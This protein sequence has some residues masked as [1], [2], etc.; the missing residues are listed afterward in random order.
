MVRLLHAGD[1]HLDSAFAALTPEQS[2]LRRTESRRTPERLV[3]WANDHGV[4]L[5][6]LAGDLFDSASLY[7]DTAPLLAQALTRFHGQAVVSMFLEQPQGH[8]QQLGLAA[9]RQVPRAPACP[10]G[11]PA[12]AAADPLPPPPAPRPG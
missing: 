5:L 7:G 9:C 4:Q 10:A 12:P 1:F 8:G 2:R 11:S 6:L 3:E